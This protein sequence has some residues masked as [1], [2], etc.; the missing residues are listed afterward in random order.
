MHL[1]GLMRTVNAGVDDRNEALRRY[2]EETGDVETF[3]VAG[4]FGVPVKYPQL[5]AVH[6]LFCCEVTMR[7]VSQVSTFGW[8]QRNDPCTSGKL[9]EKSA[10]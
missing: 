4:F 7:C 10:G 6:C 5:T 8:P 9:S 1:F 3:G 2:L